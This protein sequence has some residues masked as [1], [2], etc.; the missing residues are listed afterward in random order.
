MV[1]STQPTPEVKNYMRIVNIAFFALLIHV[2]LSNSAQARPQYALANG[3]VSCTSCHMSPAG[4]GIRTVEGKLYGAF[5]YNVKKTP[6][7]YY[8]A[9]LRS[10]LYIPERATK[11]R[12]GLGLMALIGSVN[13]PVVETDDTSTR[14][15]GSLNFGNFAPVSLRDAYVR[16]EFKGK[17]I[18]ETVL[19]GLFTPAF[20]IP[21][22][23][24]RTY[25]RIQSKTS[26]NDFMMGAMASGHLFE[27]DHFDISIGQGFQTS[28]PAQAGTF[29]QGLTGGAYYNHRIMAASLPLMLGWSGALYQRHSG[30]T[31]PLAYSLYAGWA[32]NRSFSPKLPAQLLV[33]FSEAQYWNDS[34]INP[35]FGTRI[36]TAAN[37][38]YADQIKNSTS[39]TV[40][41]YFYYDLT[42]TLNFTYKFE[43]MLPNRKYQDDYLDRHGIGLRKVLSANSQL[44]TR[45]EHS[46]VGRPDIPI[47][48][49]AKNHAFWA[50]YHF[51][52]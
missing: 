38:S 34:T 1:C 47:S 40:T 4:G 27:R 25:A 11:S 15:I 14:F 35:D 31:N 24:H 7:E 18:I 44:W 49:P 5:G 16:T 42:R 13:V 29:S 6:S 22:D 50:L 9:D 20:G 23:E 52:F 26:W 10:L 41:L 8:Q 28:A 51:W 33:E 36:V 17:P 19:F 2:L 46:L 43:H 12:D 21:T 48:S 45:Y 30:A 32:L 39:Q 3:I 37:Q